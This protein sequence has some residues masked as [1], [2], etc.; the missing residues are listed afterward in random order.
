MESIQP[1]AAVTAQAMAFA[2]LPSAPF[3][4]YAI[5]PQQPAAQA[6]T[7][8]ALS[9][10]LLVQALPPQPQVLAIHQPQAA[11]APQRTTR[12][13]VTVPQGSGPQQPVR[14]TTPDG[15]SMEVT[16]QERLEPGAV[17]TVEYTPTQHAAPPAAMAPASPAAP[18]PQVTVSPEDLDRQAMERSWW[19]YGAGWLCCFCCHAPLCAL[20]VWAAAAAAYFAKPPGERAQRPRQRGPA[21]TSAITCCAV[22]ALALIGGLAFLAGHH[23]R[24]ALLTRFHSWH[25]GHH[26]GHDHHGHHVPHPHIVRCGTHGRKPHKASSTATG[27]PAMSPPATATV[28]G[29]AQLSSETNDQ[30]SGGKDDQHVM[31]QA[32]GQGAGALAAPLPL[33]PKRTA[34]SEGHVAVAPEAAPAHAAVVI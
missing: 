1:A 15:Q 9:R 30:G 25:R 5:A 28:A 33:E 34:G 19:V 18:L 22:A 4:A 7:S 26:H 24:C 2:P 16:V 10:P 14:F 17:I 3:D 6:V 20:L 11:A 8:E 23:K 31:S 13:Q 32:P 12:I 21:K 27:S 29:P